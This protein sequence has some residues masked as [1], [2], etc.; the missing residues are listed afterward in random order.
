MSKFIIFLGFFL[1]L[2]GNA[3]MSFSQPQLV[4]VSVDTS[5]LATSP[6]RVKIVWKPDSLLVIDNYE[7]FYR[8]SDN[9]YRSLSGILPS[10]FTGFIHTEAHADEHPESYKLSYKVSGSQDGILSDPHQTI[11]LTNTPDYTKCDTTFHLVWTTYVG[12]PVK[13]YFI[14]GRTSN[15]AYQQ[16]GSTSDTTWNF[17]AIAKTTWYF[18][19]VAENANDT[20]VHSMSNL[21]SGFSDVLVDPNPDLSDITNVTFNGSVVSITSQFDASADISQ[22]SLQV[23]NQEQGPFTNLTSADFSGVGTISLTD[24]AHSDNQPLFYRM[25]FNNSC[26]RIVDS[27]NVV[28]PIKLL[29]EVNDNLV[30]LTWNQSYISGT[31]KY[32]VYLSVDGSAPVQIASIHEVKNMDYNI[33]QFGDVT[34]EQFCFQVRSIEING[35]TSQSDEYCMLRQPKVDM[36]NAFTPNGDGRNDEI[37]PEIQNADI[38]EYQFI[39]YDRYGERVF[40]SK[41]KNIAWDGKYGGKMVGEGGYLYHLK[42]KTRHNRTFEKSGSISVLFP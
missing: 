7:V 41:N 8:E 14:Y 30:S 35:F 32:T 13:S 19:V 16:L 15:G 22:I 27:T 17:Q 12:W 26:E 5:L 21:A 4:S 29:G 37:V 18:Y 28:Q 39:M 2:L 36:P 23:A 9:Q 31:E 10:T 38:S 20:K 6:G 42:F 40:E 11:Y 33:D 34:S 24:G 1:T 3:S 25:V